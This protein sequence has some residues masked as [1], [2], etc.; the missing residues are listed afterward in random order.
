[1]DELG[2]GGGGAPECD[3]HTRETKRQRG[4]GMSK[5]A[6]GPAS[7]VVEVGEGA[8]VAGTP[9]RARGRAGGAQ[10]LAPAACE[11]A[12]VGERWMEVQLGED[13]GGQRMRL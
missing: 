5:S 2:G 6:R 3:P 8:P 13:G 12:V 10:T 9:A 1:M 4:G 11:K 7:S